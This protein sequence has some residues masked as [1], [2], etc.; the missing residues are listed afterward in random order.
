[1]YKATSESRHFLRREGS[2]ST[3]GSTRGVNLLGWSS[4]EHLSEEDQRKA[5]CARVTQINNFSR[6]NKQIPKWEREQLVGE[7]MGLQER[8]RGIRPKRRAIGVQDH[9]M[10]VARARLTKA[11]F[12]VWMNEAVERLR[13]SQATVENKPF[14][15]VGE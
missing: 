14:N 7:L 8:I 13:K 9:F 12:N 3:K 11:E 2:H 4:P 5:M 10:D 15:N 6:D 1:M